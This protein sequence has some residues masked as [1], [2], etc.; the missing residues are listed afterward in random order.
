M[1][2]S[3]V[4]SLGRCRGLRG[5][6]WADVAN[7]RGSSGHRSAQGQER[8][9]HPVT[10]FEP[11]SSRPPPKSSTHERDS[12]SNQRETFTER[13]I[14]LAESS[15]RVGAARSN[16]NRRAGDTPTTPLGPFPPVPSRRG[17]LRS[18]RTNCLVRYDLSRRGPSRSGPC[19]RSG[20]RPRRA[21]RARPKPPN[22]SGRNGASR[23]DRCDGPG[24]GSSGVARWLLR[25]HL[26]PGLGRSSR[27]V[28]IV[29]KGG[30]QIGQAQRAEPQPER[31]PRDPQ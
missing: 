7:H 2:G 30:H 28:V 13:R 17:W 12:R 16:C 11:F 21:H 20:F 29:P 4:P 15:Q 10:P 27:S 19:H 23:I 6:R 31:L 8:R 26:G 24:G 9:A 14:R 18:S 22:R 5:R 1:G 3:I 25:D